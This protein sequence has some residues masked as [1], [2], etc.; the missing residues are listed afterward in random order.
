MDGVD[1]LEVTLILD[2]TW[3]I[4]HWVLLWLL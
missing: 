3:T 2:D 1:K 4:S